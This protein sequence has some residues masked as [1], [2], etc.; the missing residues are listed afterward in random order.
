MN[1][2]IEQKPNTKKTVISAKDC[3]Y[4]AVFVALTIAAQLAMS[5]L[6]GV[7]VVTVLFISF[8]FVFGIKR[9]VIAATAFTLL[10][11]FVFGVFPVVLVLYLIYFNL[12]AC[13]FGTLGKKWKP[14]VKNLIY[15]TAIACLCTACFTMLD[16]LLT[17]LFYGYTPK[18]I[19]VYFYA[20]I[21]FMI[22]H[23]VCTA[24]SVAL[25]FLPL[26]RLLRWISAQV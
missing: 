25:L 16:N 2:K 26:E 1:D 24:V 5:V 12:L 7:E 14:T 9:G 18:A 13:I 3:A 8:S 22:S 10:R 20:S 17:P 21:P 23:L 6:P 19:E 15:L 11:Q 4:I